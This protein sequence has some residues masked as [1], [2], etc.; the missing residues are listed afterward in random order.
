VVTKILEV[1]PADWVAVRYYTREASV[2]KQPSAF[3]W[4][5]YVTPERFVET[6]VE[7]ENLRLYLVIGRSDNSID[8]GLLDQYGQGHGDRD[9]WGSE[10]DPRWR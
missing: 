6:T 8:F 10:G 3:V 2:R 4:R 5:A 9:G 1:R 7:D